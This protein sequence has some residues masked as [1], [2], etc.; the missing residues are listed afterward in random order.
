MSFY[1]THCPSP[2][3]F[4][5]TGIGT[6]NDPLVLDSVGI[7]LSDNYQT[8]VEALYDSMLSWFGDTTSIVEFSSAMV[9]TPYIVRRTISNSGVITI[10]PSGN[11]GVAADHWR[12]FYSP[13]PDIDPTDSQTYEDY[14]EVTTIASPIVTD[15]VAS[16]LLRYYVLLVEYN[17][18]SSLSAESKEVRIGNTALN[19]IV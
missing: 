17:L 12:L 2:D 14:K 15:P 7:T 6:A 1:L 5:L 8:V 19:T 18:D 3:V 9:D 16:P 10:I 11:G 4:M 13:T